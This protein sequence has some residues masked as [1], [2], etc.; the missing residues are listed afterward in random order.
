MKNQEIDQYFL[1]SIFFAIFNAN[2]IAMKCMN[3]PTIAAWIRLP[4]TVQETKS[5][6]RDGMLII[7]ASMLPFA[8]NSVFE[9]LFGRS[10]L[11]NC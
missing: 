9:V 3:N 5:P 4:S 10:S 6:A 1:L 8:N 2:P 11:F 7:R